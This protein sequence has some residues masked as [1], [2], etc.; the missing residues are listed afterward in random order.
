MGDAVDVLKRLEQVEANLQKTIL[1]NRKLEARI[2]EC[3]KVNG[4]FYRMKFTS[5]IKN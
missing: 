2:A 5:F 4:D 3:E 1:N